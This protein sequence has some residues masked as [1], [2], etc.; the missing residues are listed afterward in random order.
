[1]G[2][3]VGMNE[4]DALEACLRGGRKPP[5]EGVEGD[6][7]D[8]PTVLESVCHGRGHWVGCDDDAQQMPF[9]IVGRHTPT[10]LL[11]PLPSFA[12]SQVLSSVPP[13]SCNL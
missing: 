1:M 9:H 13:L 12:R 2:Y 7:R 11:F 10:F 6:S 5:L 3:E 4:L 8:G